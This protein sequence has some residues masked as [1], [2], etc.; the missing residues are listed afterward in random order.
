MCDGYQVWDAAD[1]ADREAFAQDI[2]Y[3]RRVEE[4]KWKQFVHHQTGHKDLADITLDDL[5]NLASDRDGATFVPQPDGSVHYTYRTS[6][7][8]TTLFGDRRAWANRIFGPS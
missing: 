8:P 5:Q 7:A 3:A 4:V 6:A 2:S 1:E